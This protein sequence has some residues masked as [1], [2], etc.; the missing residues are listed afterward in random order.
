MD[1]SREASRSFTWKVKLLGAAHRRCLKM[2]IPSML[3]GLGLFHRSSLAVSSALCFRPAQK[4]NQIFCYQLVLWLE[5]AF[6]LVLAFCETDCLY[7][8]PFS[9]II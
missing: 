3:S 2:H 9:S 5:R 7:I 8:L 6:Y 1:G 4:V